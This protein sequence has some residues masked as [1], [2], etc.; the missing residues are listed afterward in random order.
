MNKSRKIMS[1]LIIL[2]INVLI[3][4]FNYGNVLNSNTTLLSDYKD[5]IN[6]N[7][8]FII[9][10]VCIIQT[11][12]LLIMVIIDLFLL[13]VI[14]NIIV[15]NKISMKENAFK[16]LVVDFLI[17]VINF[18]V[19]IIIGDY[20]INTIKLINIIPLSIVIKGILIYF[21]IYRNRFKSKYVITVLCTVMI[22]YLISI[23]F[24]LINRI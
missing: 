5:I 6:N 12:L 21:A 2:I 17:V 20:R 14:N 8:L 23:A 7:N 10:T 3:S 9:I 1:I 13:V 22:E 15:D 16:I 19:L 4:V 24:W 18:L 11:I